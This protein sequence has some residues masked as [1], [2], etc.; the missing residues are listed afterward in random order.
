MIHFFDPPNDR[1]AARHP[2]LTP[3]VAVP[4]ENLEDAIDVDNKDAARE[5]LIAVANAVDL[6]GTWL[7]ARANARNSPWILEHPTQIVTRAGERADV[8]TL[9][10]IER[11]EDIHYADRLVAQ[12]EARAGGEPPDPAVRHLGDGTRWGEPRGGVPGQTA[13]AGHLDRTCGPFGGSR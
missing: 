9:P 7:S 5:G 10:K 12:V 8:L 11:T 6:R 4:P 1:M 3:P 2:A 13:P